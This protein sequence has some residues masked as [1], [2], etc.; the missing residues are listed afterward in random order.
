[1]EYCCKPLCE[2]LSFFKA[3]HFTQQLESYNNIVFFHSARVD[4]KL[5]RY[6]FVALD[7]FDFVVDDR[8]TPGSDVFNNIQSKLDQFQLSPL[9]DLPPFQGGLAGFISYDIARK[10]EKLPNHSRVYI[11][12]PTLVLGLY[13]LV[14]A[15]DHVKQKAWIFSSGFP[16]T[17]EV[18][19][20]VR[21]KSRLDWFLNEIN[22]KYPAT[23]KLNPVVEP[24]EIVSNFTKDQY[25]NAVNKVINYISEGDIFQ[26]NLSQRF[27]C[28]LP[29]ALS[30]FDLYQRIAEHN[31]APFASYQ[32]FDDLHI[33]SSS[34]ERFLKLTHDRVE[35]RPIKGTIKRS[36]NLMEDDKLAEI[37]KNSKKDRSENAMIVD[38]MRN[39]LSK[40][41]LPHT[42]KVTQFCG[43]ESF[44]NV[45]HLVSAVEGRLSPDSGLADLLKATL[46]AGSI[47]GAPKIR[48]MEIIDE[49]EPTRR[50]PY[51]GNAVYIGFD[52]AM[53]SSV[54][55]R[56]YVIK[57]N[58]VTFQAGG[59]IVLDSDP[60][61]EYEETLVK[62]SLLE[63]ALNNPLQQTDL[64]YAE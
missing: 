15:I 7:P 21:R 38:L 14:M 18:T 31:P 30:P 60:L 8:G 55:I 58:R 48:A 52:G 22:Q 13:D 46:P 47:T 40:V 45:H 61:Q 33:L 62:A 41:C 6:S 26:A 34:P 20:I 32:R 25:L 5:A 24:I 51:C 17:I 1:M 29:A 42:V 12:Y 19:R 4:K 27:D 56:T 54:L 23:K 63:F 50:G 43:L 49:L 9:P 3:T 57:N 16:E 35:V 2:E 37:L 39:D 44:E 64:K 11:E 10:L 36:H 28:R 59:A 53:D